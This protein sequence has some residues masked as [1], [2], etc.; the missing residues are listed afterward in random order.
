MTKIKKTLPT[1]TSQNFAGRVVLT[2]QKNQIGVME[3]VRSIM[4]NAPMLY[5]HFLNETC[6]IGDEVSMYITN[7]RPKR[8]EAQ[9]NYFH[10]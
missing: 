7:K 6:K 8:S 5:R 4:M 1:Y 2:Q 9:N 3:S 10:L